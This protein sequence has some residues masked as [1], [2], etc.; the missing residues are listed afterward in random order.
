[1]MLVSFAANCPLRAPTNRRR[2]Q[3]NFWRSDA[4]ERTTLLWH[5]ISA[6]YCPRCSSATSD[7]VH[8]MERLRICMHW[9]R[10]WFL[11]V[12]SQRNRRDSQGSLTSLVSI[13][14][15]GQRQ[16]L[17][18]TGTGYVA[19]KKPDYEHALSRSDADVLMFLFETLG[20]WSEPVVRLFRRM[21]DK[22]RNKL[23]KRQYEHEV[24]WST[25]TW[26]ALQAQRL[27]VALHIASAWEIATEMQLAGGGGEAPATA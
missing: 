21:K 11:R 8:V 27:S 24:S 20:G 17:P 19:Y 16:L 1:M 22:V 25:S 18:G 14:I 7:E 9:L 3:A 12:M 5:R 2:K 13:Y 26:L 10:N 15:S 4:R 6:Q 23:T